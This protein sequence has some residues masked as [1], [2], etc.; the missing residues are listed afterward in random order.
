MNKLRETMNACRYRYVLLRDLLKLA[1]G[2]RPEQSKIRGQIMAR[3][4]RER[5]AMIQAAQALR[6]RLAERQ[7]VGPKIGVFVSY[8]SP[9]YPALRGVKNVFN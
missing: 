9:D 6:A 4:N 7:A 1:Q 5:Y 2:Q 8:Y 3:M